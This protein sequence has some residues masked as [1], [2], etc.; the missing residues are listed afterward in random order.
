MNAINGCEPSPSSC[1]D[2]NIGDVIGTG[3]SDVFLP[4][5]FLVCFVGS[6]TGAP[7]SARYEFDNL[8][9]CGVLK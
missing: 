7:S 8:D 9:A 5:D 2:S 6:A 4:P 3:V 1:Y